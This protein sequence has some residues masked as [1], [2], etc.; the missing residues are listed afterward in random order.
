M[1]METLVEKFVDVFLGNL[2][3]N[4]DVL[5][6]LLEDEG[7]SSEEAECLLAFVP[8]AFAHVLLGP[9]GV[10]LPSGFQAWDPDTNE[11]QAGLLK[12]E[13][14]FLAAVSVATRKTTDARVREV[15]ASSAEW[16]IVRKLTSNGGTAEGC[17]LTEPLL[18]RVPLAHF[19]RSRKPRSWWAWLTGR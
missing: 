4:P 16:G 8:M 2:T 12:E 19:R 5:V 14:I 7:I 18:A 10:G 11:R 6:H 1:A 9:M 3:A 15:A 13:P 17:V